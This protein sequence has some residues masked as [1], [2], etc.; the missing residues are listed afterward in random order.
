MPVGVHNAR[1][2]TSQV[3]VLDDTAPAAW[4]EARLSGEFGA[5]TRTVP[6][7]YPAYAR[8][9]HPPR[10]GDD[11]PV[12]W[13]EVAA[14]TGRTVH[15]LAQWHAV[16]DSPDM[17]NF[18]ESRW[19]DGSP[20]TGSLDEEALSPLCD[21]LAAHTTTPD[22]CFY[23]LW[24]GWG[25]IYGSPA[26]AN[27]GSREPVASL[28]TAQELASPRLH[29]P[30]RDYLLL[31]GPM[32]GALAL[33]CYGESWPAWQSPNLLW[34]ADRAWVLASE[35]DFNSTLVAGDT[36]L[37][38]DI[39]ACPAL[40]SWPVRPHDSL[41]SDGDTVN[42]TNQRTIQHTYL[43]EGFFRRLTTRFSGR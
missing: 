5:V 35:I 43:R 9:L 32:S 36:D 14:T 6:D 17:A 28:F 20:S 38:A 1:M 19:P 13:A 40:E 30:S 7:G 41:G 25:W 27:L 39:L 37:I 42:P 34:P 3:R 2:W 22:D 4:L 23:G 12:T 24:E 10:D 15:A 21:V 11:E 16:V 18:G 26:I 8:I 29:L 31:R 33:S